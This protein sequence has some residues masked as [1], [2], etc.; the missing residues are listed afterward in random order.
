LLREM[1][2]SDF[3]FARFYARRVR[4]IFPAL[5]LVLLSC[6]VLGWFVLLPDEFKWLG[7]QIFGGAA[8]FSNF[9]L[10]GDAGYF[11]PSAERNPLLH[12]WSLGIEEQFYIVWPLVL[13]AAFQFRRSV[14]W[15]IAAIFAVSFLANALT[16][17]SNPVGAF[18]WPFTRAWEL[19]SGG[20]LAWIAGRS[21]LKAAGAPHWLHNAR[22]LLGLALIVAGVAILNKSSA[23]PGWWAILPVAGAVLLISADA[24][25]LNR[26][27]LASRAFVFIGLISYPLYLWHWPLLSFQSIVDSDQSSALGRTVIISI[28]MVL[29][30]LTYETVEKPIRSGKPFMA[31][32]VSMAMVVVGCVGLT[33]VYRNGYEGR[34]PAALRG[35]A[36]AAVDTSQWRV[37][38]CLL[39]GS[40]SAFSSECAGDGRRPLLLLWGDSYAGS[41]YPGLKSLQAHIEFGLAQYTT[42]GCPP[43]PSFVVEARPRCVASNDFV[44]SVI[45][46][47]KPDI[48][49]LYSIWNYEGLTP[50]RLDATVAA[51]QAAGVK[52]IVMMGPP[53]QWVGGLPQ[54]IYEYY[55]AHHL[56]GAAPP[57]RSRMHLNAGVP[58]FD[59]VLRTKAI[60]L[61]IEYISVWKIMC[62]QEGCL[63]RAG[64]ALITED[65]G[66]LSVAGATYLAER[67]SPRLFPRLAEP[68]SPFRTKTATS[69]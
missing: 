60:T 3:S 15:V 53:P 8:F 47:V 13:L 65:Y 49:L 61:G 33:T 42:A 34:L 10:L 45:R 68:D 36:T 69:Q 12:L 9:V 48:V 20:I 11:G 1:E 5:V 32:R 66:H 62:N 67:L 25:W 26:N 59:Q 55:R 44:L 56:E 7:K 28:S 58:D 63:T 29:A 23:F 51:L 50:D 31:A 64:D 57:E 19:M 18:Y 24:A 14:G 6:F 43:I 54:A 21:A 52:R 27:V 4:R 37:S 17:G 40:D 41:L 30:W 38:K 16:I 22:A 39:D 2:S 35:L 46:S